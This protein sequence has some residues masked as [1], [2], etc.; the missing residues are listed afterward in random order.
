MKLLYLVNT[1]VYGG[2][3]LQTVALALRMRRRG[4]Q[5][6]VVSMTEPAALTDTLSAAGVEWTSLGMRRGVPSPRALISYARIVGEFGPDLVHANLTHANIMARIGRLLAPVPALISTIHSTQDR[7]KWAG[8]AYRLTD[9]LSELTTGPSAAVADAYVGRGSVPSGKMRIVPNGIDCAALDAARGDSAESRRCVRSEF[10]IDENAFVWLAAGRLMPAKDYPTLLDA[11]SGASVPNWKL[12]IAG[13]GP[14]LEE[15]RKT[16]E[17]K[18]LSGRVKLLGLR[19]DLPALMAGADAFV[20]SS[21]WEG[22][23]LVVAEALNA[24]LPVVSTDSGGVRDIIVSD[25]ARSDPGI[26]LVPIRDAPALR[27]AMR[28]VYEAMQASDLRIK[29]SLAETRRKSARSR[30]DLESVASEWERIY[31]DL[32]QRS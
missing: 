10:D 6:L 8:A 30:F 29:G 4:H 3:E 20:S 32:A 22:F 11:F 9:G 1:L 24:G 14:L 23:G 12:W 26:A 21:A 16:I 7:Q 19:K 27:D 5:V 25:E 28:R 31:L 13:E 15:T 2:A 17:K 18:G